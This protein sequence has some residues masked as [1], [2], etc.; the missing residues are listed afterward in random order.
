MA[1]PSWL[2]RSDW[3]GRLTAGAAS[4]KVVYFQG[5][6]AY[7]VDTA[8]DARAERFATLEAPVTNAEMARDGRSILAVTKKGAWQLAPDG[9]SERLLEAR[10]PFEQDARAVGVSQ[11]RIHDAV[12]ESVDHGVQGIVIDRIELAR[13]LFEVR[14]RDPGDQHAEH[15]VLAG[16]YS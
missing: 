10:R 11:L 8:S 3:F 5:K 9:S 12:S 7:M 4:R 1:N 6:R 14:A 15:G 2:A 13:Q 16:K